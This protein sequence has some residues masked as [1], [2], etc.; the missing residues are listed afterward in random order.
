MAASG[1]R[2]FDLDTLSP[3]LRRLLPVIDA[4]V[5]LAFDTMVPVAE[6]YM[7]FN[8]LWTDRTGNARAGL[9][10]V[11][12]SDP[13][14]RHELVLFHTMPYGIWLEVR[15]SGKYAIIAPTLEALGPDL[16][17][18]ISAA[19]RQAIKLAKVA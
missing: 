9:R 18:R 5:D 16:M 19:A 11:H 13:M 7:R 12:E 3:S 8:A 4:G 2:V 10:A 15:F 1:S 6:S 14:V 17:E